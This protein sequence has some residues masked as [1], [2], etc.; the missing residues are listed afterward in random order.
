MDEYGYY[1][2]WAIHPIAMDNIIAFEFDRKVVFPMSFR[3]N[4]N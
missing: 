1:S 4:G 2:S 3:N